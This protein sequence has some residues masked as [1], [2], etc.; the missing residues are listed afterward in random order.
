[1]S[2]TFHDPRGKIRVRKAKKKSPAELRRLPRA[3]IAL[4]M[5]EAET[6][7]E[8]ADSSSANIEKTSGG[9]QEPDSKAGA[10]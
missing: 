7:I 4:A 3:L 6:E 9:R 1:M 5:A 8:T 10:A 2:R